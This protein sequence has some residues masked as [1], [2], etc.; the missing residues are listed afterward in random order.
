MTL[1]ACYTLKS[2][3]HHSGLGYEFINSRT[4]K[5]GLTNF[6]VTVECLKVRHKLVSVTLYVDPNSSKF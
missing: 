1:A 4:L 5:H 3:S 6:V 2:N